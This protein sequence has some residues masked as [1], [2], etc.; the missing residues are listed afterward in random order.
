MARINGW[1]VPTPPACQQ[2]P[3]P[4]GFASSCS[5]DLRETGETYTA[6]PARRSNGL[7]T[8]RHG[9]S[10]SSDRIKQ[11]INGLESGIGSSMR[12]FLDHLLLSGLQIAHVDF[13]WP[14]YGSTSLIVVLVFHFTTFPAEVSP[15]Y[16]EL[17]I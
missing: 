1:A 2:H 4:A 9:T 3:S 11:S 8:S 17:I 15:L 12:K 6:H 16:L 5:L 13:T 14:S 7:W 10:K